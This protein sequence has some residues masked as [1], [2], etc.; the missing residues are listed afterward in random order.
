MPSFLTHW[1]ILIETARRSQDAGSDLGSL[2]IDKET[3]RRRASSST[4]M[5][6]VWDTGPLPHI[7]A[8]YPGSDISAMAYLGALAPDIPY[9]RPRHFW[10]KI[11]GKERLAQTRMQP[12]SMEQIPWA[13]LL[14]TNRSGD[15]LLAFLDQL[16]RI[17]SP[18]LRSQALAFAMGYVSHIA[19]DIALHPYINALAAT[20][21]PHDIPG[22]FP[23]LDLHAY[24]E[25]CLDEHLAS[26][27]FGRNLHGRFQRTWGGYIE[28]A[29]RQVTTPDTIAAQTL[30]LLAHSIESTYGLNEAQ[31]KHFLKDYLAGTRGLRSHLAGSGL[32]SWLPINA[33]VRR[34]AHDPIIA[35][36]RTSGLRTDVTTLGDVLEYAIRLSERFCRS[37]IA[38]YTT[39]RNR[40]TS[41]QKRAELRYDLRNW[42]LNSGY[43]LDVAFDQEIMLSFLHNWIYFAELWPHTSSAK[44][45]AT[46]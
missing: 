15:F 3:L 42:D 36:L 7:D 5:G 32:F 25:L 41:E 20:Y 14:H 8:H 10:K 34:R 4:P 11:S 19:A 27:Y 23:P 9:F 22:I 21:K 31:S 30:T 2:I 45:Q 40:Q 6:A 29:A 33:L 16:A 17:P 39:L 35:T 18:A 44:D 26:H 43:T 37:A 24:V 28:P 1:Y 13:R 46:L 12:F 38:Y